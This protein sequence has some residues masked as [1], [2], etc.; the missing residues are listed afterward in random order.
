MH[1]FNLL[2]KHINPDALKI[3][4]LRFNVDRVCCFT[5][6]TI[7][8]GV[9]KTD[10][11]S[12]KFTETSYIRNE[13][14]YA[15]IDAALCLGSVIPGTKRDT[16]LRNHSF[17]CDQEELR[18][19]KREEI[20]ELLL[21]IPRTPFLV[22]VS[23]S[24][25]KHI[26]YKCAVNYRTDSFWVSTDRHERINF[27]VFT[28]N[29]ILPIM[30]RW[31]TIV[32]EKANTAQQPTWFTKDQI[33]GADPGPIRIS[34]YGLDQYMEEDRLLEIHRRSALFELILHLLNKS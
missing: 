10:L 12:E 32:P 24:F 30:Q 16:S 2:A 5:G 3:S 19:L 6:E 33:A 7:R 25:K 9:K 8:E 1:P 21:N 34:Q 23:F 26:S 18:F 20:L 27:P 22:A 14:E 28:V 11:V 13:S 31:Y 17:Y 29:S 15:S 4:V